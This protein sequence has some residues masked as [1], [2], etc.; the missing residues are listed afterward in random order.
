MPEKTVFPVTV[1]SA[2]KSGKISIKPYVDNKIKNMGLENYDLV[3]HDGVFHEEQLAAIETNG[4]TRYLTGLNEF[5]PEIKLIQDEKV[6]KAKIKEIRQIVAQLEKELATNIVDPTDDKFWDKVELLRPNNHDFWSK[7]SIRCG[8]KDIPL[9]PVKDSF[10]LIKIYA[11]EAGGFPLIAPSYE[12][13]RMMDKPPK[14]YLDKATETIAIK[15]E[16][17]KLRNK[18]LSELQKL[19]DTNPNKLLYVAK[20]V[21]GTSAQY[22]KT[23][24]NDVVYDNMDKYITGNGI[25]KNLKR[26]AL[27]FTEASELDMETL[28]LKALVKDASFYRFIILK[29]DGHIYDVETGSLLGK[30]IQECVEYFR[31][32]LNDSVL[33]PIMKKVEKMWNQ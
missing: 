8:N 1:D 17:S 2:H 15:T 30:N 19:Y 18:A 31:N 5:A 4:V 12:M 20:C 25:E 26:A 33:Q 28:K 3:V 22:K 27:T 16:L 13:A 32:P 24:P 21:D 23:T 7:I 10:D 11:I 29:S 14:F 6:K 9:D